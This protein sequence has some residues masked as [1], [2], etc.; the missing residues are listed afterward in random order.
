MENEISYMKRF[1]ECHCKSINYIT[2]GEGF[3]I[4]NIRGPTIGMASALTV[5]PWAHN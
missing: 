1:T 4:L 2:C 3:S 5:L